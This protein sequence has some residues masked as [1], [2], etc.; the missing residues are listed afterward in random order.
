MVGAEQGAYALSRALKP[1]GTLAII[2][3]RAVRAPVAQPPGADD[4][5]ARDKVAM[6]DR[7]PQS[8]PCQPYG[9]RENRYVRSTFGA[10]SISSDTQRARTFVAIQ[11]LYIHKNSGSCT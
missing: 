1:A 11:T 9:R 7:P 8:S 3:H 4:E 2:F 5:A 10:K 6:L